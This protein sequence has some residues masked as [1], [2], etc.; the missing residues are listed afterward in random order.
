MA[1]TCP[2]DDHL[3]RQVEELWVLV[4]HAEFAEQRLDH[5][6]A[7]RRTRNGQSFVLDVWSQA[8]RV[9]FDCH[10]KQTQRKIIKFDHFGWKF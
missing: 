1:I 3:H 5:L 8:L 7:C 2:A 6:V 4:S 10:L 9:H